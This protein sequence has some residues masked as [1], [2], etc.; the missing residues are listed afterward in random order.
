[1]WEML[2]MKNV[3]YSP[4]SE[5][6]GTWNHQLQKNFKSGVRLIQI[7]DAVAMQQDNEPICL[8]RSRHQQNNYEAVLQ[9]RSGTTTNVQ[10]IFVGI[11][12]KWIESEWHRKDRC[13]NLVVCSTLQEW[14]FNLSK[15]EFVDAIYIR[16]GCSP[17]WLPTECVCDAAFNINHAL[18]C[19]VGGLVTLRYNEIR[20]VA[21]LLSAMC[22]DV[23]KEPALDETTENNLRADVSMLC[24][25]H[26][27]T[28]GFSTH[29]KRQET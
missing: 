1:M 3:S 15:L 12:M 24:K 26:L 11:T 19:K 23:R 7:S 25:G 14:G 10:I 27:L 8:Q 13:I 29:R 20:D 18:C 17:N 9:R 5:I 22:K 6:R 2:A 28:L 16:Y 21:E 4:T